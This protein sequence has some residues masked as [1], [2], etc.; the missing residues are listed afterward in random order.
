M[1]WLLE[2]EM[3]QGDDTQAWASWITAQSV[4]QEHVRDAVCLALMDA[5]HVTEPGWL[6]Q[7]SPDHTRLELQPGFGIWLRVVRWRPVVAAGWQRL[8]VE[9]GDFPPTPVEG[10]VKWP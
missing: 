5:G 7:A 9:A 2:A 4:V 1:T 6:L 10:L 8:W 3:P